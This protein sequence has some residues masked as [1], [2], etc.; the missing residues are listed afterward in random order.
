MVDE[1]KPNKKI[2][3]YAT[4]GV[5]AAPIIKEVI[6]HIAPLLGVK[7]INYPPNPH[8]VSDNMLDTQ[9]HNELKKIK[10]R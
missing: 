6:E 9:Y 5:V 4:G 8:A 1:P 3:A 10:L 7:P 2:S